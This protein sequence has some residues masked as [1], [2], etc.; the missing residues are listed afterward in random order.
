MP[1]WTV[2][3]ASIQCLETNLT[4]SSTQKVLPFPLSQTHKKSH[5]LLLDPISHPPPP[6]LGSHPHAISADPA[7]P[8]QPPAAGR[9][10]AP[11]P[12]LLV[13]AQHP[14]T[15]EPRWRPRRRGCEI[16]RGACWRWSPHPA[17]SASVHGDLLPVT[18]WTASPSYHRRRRPRPPSAGHQSVQL[19]PATNPSPT[20]FSRWAS[21]SR[22]PGS[23]T[24]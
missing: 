24:Y 16:G 10:A 23:T 7:P 2:H 11:V 17:S 4:K 22:P 6:P 5:S 9:D 12:L 1:I 14:Q 21:S 20:S 19:P 13:T 15:R 18:S 8:E 3:T